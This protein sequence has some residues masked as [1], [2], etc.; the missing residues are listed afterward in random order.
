MQEPSNTGHIVSPPEPVRTPVAA[1][2]CADYELETV[3]SAL[4]QV[5]APLGGMAAFVKPGERIALKPNLLMPAA[6]ER[7]IATHPTVVAAVALEVMEA[8]GH[9]VVVESPGTR[10]LHVKAVMERVFRRTGYT[11]MA[12]RHGFELEP[13]HGLPDR[14]G[15]RRPP[16]RSA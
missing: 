4:R 15:A 16:S 6:P 14:V 3:R 11:E 10:T 8:G 12:E 2:R 13:R 1:A 5:L 9:P 7:A